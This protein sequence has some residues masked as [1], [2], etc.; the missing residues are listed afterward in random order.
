MVQ[1]GS[2]MVTSAACS[3]R[4]QPGR[5]DRHLGHVLAAGRQRRHGGG[6]GRGDAAAGHGHGGRA[7]LRRGVVDH[8]DLHDLPG[9]GGAAAEEESRG[10]GTD[11]HPLMVARRPR[12]RPPPRPLDTI[13]DNRPGT[14]APAPAQGGA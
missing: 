5:V 6:L 8:G 14:R 7:G 3:A 9:P 1:P 11:P 4:A 13:R 10:D 12:R 2:A